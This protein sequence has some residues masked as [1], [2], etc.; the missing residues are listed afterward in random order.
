MTGPLSPRERQ[1]LEGMA[2]G[3]SNAAIGLSLYIAQDTVK[4]HARRIYQK[5]G[6][7]DRANAVAVG[8][9]LGLLDP[10]RPPALTPDRPPPRRTPKPKPVCRDRQVL[11]V[12]ARHQHIRAHLAARHPF[13]V[14]YD[15]LRN[16]F[17]TDRPAT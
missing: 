16:L 7:R 2:A 4:T 14:I 13:C 12:L 8:Y 6:A 17:P 5:L 9:Q 3:L 10:T 11:A 1:I 15:D